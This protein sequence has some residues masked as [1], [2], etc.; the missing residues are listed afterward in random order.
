MPEAFETAMLPPTLIPKIFSTMG[1]TRALSNHFIVEL[2]SLRR[3][4]LLNL[5]L[6]C[7]GFGSGLFVTSELGLSPWNVF[8]M[9]QSLQLGGTIGLWVVLTSFALLLLWIPLK[10]KM[11]LG[12]LMNTLLVGPAVDVCVYLVPSAT[13]TLQGIV[14][15]AIGM[16]LC[17]LGSGLYITRNLGPGPRDGIMTALAK[18]GIPIWIARNSLEAIALVFGIILGGKAG[19]GTVVFVLGIG[20]S[21]QFFMKRFSALKN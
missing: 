14:Y 11:G 18:R 16:T 21:V 7:F 5:G 3:F 12:T 8:H 17:G 20:P 10:E 1:A 15:L 2:P 19:L 9:G 4:L 13:S 6:F